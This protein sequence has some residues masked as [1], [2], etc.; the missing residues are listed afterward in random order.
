MTEAEH[1]LTC[2]ISSKLN[3]VHPLLSTVLVTLQVTLHN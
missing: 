2:R 3:E 1:Q